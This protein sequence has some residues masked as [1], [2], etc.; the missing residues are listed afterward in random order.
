VTFPLDFYVLFAIWCAGMPVGAFAFLH[1]VV[2]RADAYTAADRMTKLAWSLI[3][4][5]G[6]AAL[7]L[8]RPQDQTFILWMAALV[9]VLVYIVDVRPK[10]NEVQRGNR[11]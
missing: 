3:T 6:L 7:F 4:G 2:Q 1:A 8:F 9:A 11:W 10:L 5:G